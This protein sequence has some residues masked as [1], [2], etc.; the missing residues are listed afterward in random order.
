MLKKSIF[1]VFFSVT[2][3][4]SCQTKVKTMFY[5]L[6]N[7]DSDLVS[8]NKTEHL[9]TILNEVQPDLF[10]VCE[11]KSETASNYLYQ[12]AVVPFNP[13]FQKAP[14][15]YSQSPATGLLQ[16]VYYNSKKLVLDATKVIPTGIRDINHY[17]FTINT[18]D[19]DIN[20][21]KLEVFVTHLKASTGSDN[22][23]K[24][25]NSV[26]YF[27]DELD[28]LPKNSF[29]LFSG[30]LNFY[31]SNE[32]G[33]RVLTD[34]RNSIQIIDPIDRPA[35]NFP[36]NPNIDDP[37]EFYSSSSSYFWRNSSFAD[38]HS[39]STRTFQLNGD[40]AGGGMDDRFDFI[41]MSE[42]LKTSSDLFYVENSY[43]TIGNNGNCYN[44]FVSNTSCNGEYSQS[45]RNALYQFS[46]HLPIVMSLETPSNPLSIKKKHPILLSS[47]NIVKNSITLALKE[48]VNSIIIYNQLGQIIYQRKATNETEL[49]I[50]T[51]KFA[52]GVYFL[53]ADT[54]TPLKFVKN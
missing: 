28:K 9:Q 49:I 44:S 14:F 30:D 36:N 29:V 22:R 35:E 21:I 4:L 23:Q 41:L 34:S 40:G 11:L 20:P 18:E 48:K 39:Q 47:A 37:F 19:A 54:F 2:F 51:S 17:T 8:I 31:T 24:R 3:S 46:D 5:N 33:Y 15:R 42:N 7:Y 1:L 52:N 38:I 32:D 13:D 27:L 45:L 43:R 25:Y 26:I 12:N 16:M 50:Y 10:M 53:K 6:L